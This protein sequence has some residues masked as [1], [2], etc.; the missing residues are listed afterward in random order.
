MTWWFALCG[1]IWSLW[2]RGRSSTSI[3]PFFGQ[4]YARIT[5][6]WGWSRHGCSHK[7]PSRIIPTS[8]SGP[9]P[10]VF[11]W[12]LT[13]Y[14]FLVHAPLHPRG[15]RHRPLLFV[16]AAFVYVVGRRPRKSGCKTTILLGNGETIMTAWWFGT[17][18]YFPIYWEQSSQLTN[19]FQGARLNHQPDDN[20]VSLM[21][22]H[23]F[24]KP[25]D[26]FNMFES[27]LMTIIMGNHG[28]WV[29][30]SHW[31]NRQRSIQQSCCREWTYRKFYRR[32]K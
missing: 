19:I 8:P 28:Q 23:I 6:Q 12:T 3:L 22:S 25:N 5:S 29:W 26:G 1:I 27:I 2:E 30:W 18:I 21:V 13:F 20:L 31:W 11:W 7:I 9:N 10:N 16:K 17:F 24:S 32:P 4:S 15:R 14:F